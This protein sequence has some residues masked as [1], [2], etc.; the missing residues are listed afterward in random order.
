MVVL[1]P[2]STSQSV[3][4]FPLTHRRP[5]LGVFVFRF[6]CDLK[7]STP[8]L[9]ERVHTLPQPGHST[10]E[11]PLCS[12][13]WRAMGT[14][15]ENVQLPDVADCNSSFFRDRACVIGSGGGNGD[16]CSSFGGTL[17]P[18]DTSLPASFS[19]PDAWS[20]SVPGP[21]PSMI[22]KVSWRST[23]NAAAR[24]R[25]STC[26]SVAFASYDHSRA[27]STSFIRL[28]ML[29]RPELAGSRTI[30]VSQS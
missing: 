28:S 26:T 2:S 22:R 1:S 6:G 29:T 15:P 7:R 3:S 23:S 10:A 13:R 30:C 16:G 12:K 14:T 20:V 18:A 9:G 8:P 11:T 19:V 17:C 21:S 4:P 27:A 25:Y 5:V 24:S